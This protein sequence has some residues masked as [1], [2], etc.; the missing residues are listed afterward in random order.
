MPLKDDAWDFLQQSQS[1]FG[2]VKIA[3][4]YLSVKAYHGAVPST[5][6]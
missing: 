4:R 1:R 5:L 3:F 6:R 2:I